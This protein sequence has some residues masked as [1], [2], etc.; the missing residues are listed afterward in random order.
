[1]RGRSAGFVVYLGGDVSMELALPT[2]PCCVSVSTRCASLVSSGG[3]AC[4]VS[5]GS[6]SVSKVSHDPFQ[7]RKSLFAS[8]AVCEAVASVVVCR[9]FGGLLVCNSSWSMWMS[10]FHKRVVLGLLGS[11]CSGFASS[12]ITAAFASWYAL[13]NGLG[14]CVHV[15]L[16]L[17]YRSS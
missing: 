2:S 11:W 14:M 17:S 5:L 7:N 8:V 4:G 3:R 9:V 12:L 16:G 1:M 13:S 15:V 6:G 10:S